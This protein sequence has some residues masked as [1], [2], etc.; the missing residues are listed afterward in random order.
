[1]TEIQAEALDMVHFTAKKHQI[2]IKLQK[3]DIE[4]FNNLALFHGRE[5]FVDDQEH[6]RHF[7]RLWLKNEEMAWETPETLR[8][9]TAELY[10]KKG[11]DA[12]PK[13]DVDHAPPV[14]RVITRHMRCS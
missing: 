2:S 9:Q 8:S 14:P 11:L 12:S 10:E 4:I 13:W 1:M 7:L 6:K 3:G 5:G